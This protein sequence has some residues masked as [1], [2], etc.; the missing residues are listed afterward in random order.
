MTKG[1]PAH[2]I[3]HHPTQARGY[4]HSHVLFQLEYCPREQIFI[5][6]LSFQ[7]RKKIIVHQYSAVYKTLIAKDSTRIRGL[8]RIRYARLIRR[9]R[10][11]EDLTGTQEGVEESRSRG[12]VLRIP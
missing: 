7:L 2:P 1:P 11:V 12:N 5:H 6:I 10:A 8:H 3:A 4:N 9:I